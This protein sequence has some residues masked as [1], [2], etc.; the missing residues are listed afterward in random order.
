MSFHYLPLIILP[1]GLAFAVL[2]P[3]VVIR[4]HS[5]QSTNCGHVFNLSLSQ[6]VFAPHAMGK[7]RVCCPSCG[8]VTWVIPVSKNQET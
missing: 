4:N 5:Y 2:I 7:K 1:F 3:W 8:Q 6:G